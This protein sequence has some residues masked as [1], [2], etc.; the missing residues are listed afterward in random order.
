MPSSQI[1]GNSATAIASSVSL[2]EREYSH[3]SSEVTANAMAKN[4][5]SFD[6]ILRHYYTGVDIERFEVDSGEL[7]LL[8]EQTNE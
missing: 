1:T 6:E 5:S 2:N 4:G 3:S 7:C 8:P